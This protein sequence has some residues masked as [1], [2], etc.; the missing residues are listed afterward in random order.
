MTRTYNIVDFGAVADGR[1]CTESIQAAINACW[2]DGGG[3]VEIPTGEFT[4]GDIRLRSHITLH[5][6]KNAVLKGLLDPGAYYH[7]TSDTIEPIDWLPDVMRQIGRPERRIVAE[8][9]AW[10]HGLI[11]AVGAEDIAILGEEGSVIDGQDCYNPEGEEHY[12]GPHAISFHNCRNLRFSG[13]TVRS[14]ANWAHAIF[15]SQNIHMDHVTVYAGHDGV[16]FTTCRNVTV[17]DCAFYTGDDSI[18]GLDL[19]NVYVA[20]TVMNTACSAFRLGGTNVLIEDCRMYGPAAYLFRGSLSKEEKAA[21]VPSLANPGKL[22]RDAAGHRFN[23]LS[24]FTYYADFSRK[25]DV[26]PGNIVMQNCVIENADRL[27]HYNYSGNEPWQKNAPMRSFRFDGIQATGISLP[28]N[29]Y[30]DPDVPL[31]LEIVRSNIT[32]KEG[33]D[34]AFLHLCHHAE[35]LLDTVQIRYTGDTPPESP[36]IQLWSKDGRILLNDVDAPN[37]RIEEATEPFFAQPI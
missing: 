21:C 32:F 7:T 25:I 19:V 23:M 15:D 14:S 5:L 10:G 34:V 31:Q 8:C 18:A 33:K 20:R 37:L 36:L 11:R 9:G 30:G 2:K 24:A 26:Q 3:T 6:Q 13:Y 29:A 22:E 28:L 4:T 12:R 16:H 27:L 1:D 17:E 35:V